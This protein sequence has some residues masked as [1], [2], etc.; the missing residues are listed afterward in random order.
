[1]ADGDD[2]GASALYRGCGERL[3]AVEGRQVGDE[4]N[5]AEGEGPKNGGIL[6]TSQKGQRSHLSVTL[7]NVP[8]QQLHNSRSVL[9]TETSY[10]MLDR[11]VKD[12]S[13]ETSAR[14]RCVRSWGKVTAFKSK[15]PRD[16]IIVCA[17][18]NRRI[19]QTRNSLLVSYIDER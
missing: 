9:D 6:G 5:V 16:Q 14:R 4:C 8:S 15:T 19:S 13:S 18:W 17:R 11:I 3:E 1:M 12:H 7:E 2:A 10:K